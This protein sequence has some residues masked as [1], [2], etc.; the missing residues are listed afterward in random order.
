LQYEREEEEGEHRL[1][2]SFVRHQHL[3]FVTVG[4]RCTVLIQSD[5]KSDGLL[6]MCEIFSFI[7]QFNY[8]GKTLKLFFFFLI[9]H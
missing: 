9:N 7:L 1:T 5:K 4:H 8:L 2:P 6:F 3:T